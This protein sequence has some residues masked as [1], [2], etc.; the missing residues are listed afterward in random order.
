MTR[1]TEC[2]PSKHKS[3]RSNPNSAKICRKSKINTKVKS[4][5]KFLENNFNNE[6]M[7][8]LANKFFICDQKEQHN[9]FSLIWH[10]FVCTVNL[11]L[12]WIFGTEENRESPYPERDSS[13][14]TRLRI[15]W[16]QKWESSFLYFSC[17]AFFLHFCP[18]W[19]QIMILPI[20][21]SWV[22]DITDI[23][24]YVKLHRCKVV[25]PWN[26]TWTDTLK[27]TARHAA[28]NKRSR[29]FAHIIIL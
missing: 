29:C 14:G 11:A 5:C 21:T 4:I 10:V 6:L 23:C 16:Q 15:D 24:K 2:L 27:H 17:I 1:V 9:F 3:L 7:L 28:C 20:S 13:T 22:A 18:G 12:Y 19:P 8:A 26:L 25:Y